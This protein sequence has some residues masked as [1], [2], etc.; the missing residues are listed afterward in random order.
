MRS[1]SV[2][3]AGA[4]RPLASKEPQGEFVFACFVAW[5]QDLVELGRPGVRS[6][7]LGG[8]LQYLESVVFAT[9]LHR[10]PSFF[11]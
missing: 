4:V 10:Q 2:V 1:T 8:L 5:M 11:L 6:R 7:V 3:S 9:C